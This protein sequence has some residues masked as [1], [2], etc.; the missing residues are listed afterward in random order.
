MKTAKGYTKQVNGGRPQFISEDEYNK[1]MLVY[2]ETCDYKRI[3][4]D[5]EDYFTVSYTILEN[6][7]IVRLGWAFYPQFED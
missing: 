1:L 6:R 3:V 7:C 2:D 4:H 5:T